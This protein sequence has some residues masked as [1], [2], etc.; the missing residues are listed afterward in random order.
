VPDFSKFLGDGS[1][2]THEHAGQF[3]AQFR[4]LANIE[5]LFGSDIVKGMVMGSLTGGNGY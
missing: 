1:R 2:I 4:E 5:V 3:L